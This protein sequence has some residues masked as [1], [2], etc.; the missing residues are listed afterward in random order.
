MVYFLKTFRVLT[1]RFG[2]WDTIR[3]DGGKEFNL[4]EFMQ[5]FYGQMRND[6]TRQAVRRGKSTDVIILY[7]INFLCI[8]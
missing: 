7:S 1:Q 4:I 5:K 3:I 6:T 2:L 8:N